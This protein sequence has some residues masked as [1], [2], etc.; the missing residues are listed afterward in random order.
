[1]WGTVPHHELP[2]VGTYAH[3]SHRIFFH[4]DLLE[5]EEVKDHALVGY[6]NWR[7]KQNF[8]LNEM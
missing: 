4:D 5:N 3:Q 2:G 8:R 7:R 1:M 6:V